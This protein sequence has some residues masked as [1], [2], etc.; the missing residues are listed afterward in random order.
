MLGG[1]T[2]QI[3]IAQHLVGPA[4]RAP[5]LG[6]DAVRIVVGQLFALLEVRVQLD[7]VDGR[8]HTCIANEQVDVAGQE[9]ADANV[10]DQAAFASFD[11]R[12]PCLDEL[13]LAWVRP[14]NQIEIDVVE[15]HTAHALL[16]GEQSLVVSMVAAGQLGRDDDVFARH[17]GF[18]DGATHHT[19]VLI[20]ERGVDEAVTLMDGGLDGVHTG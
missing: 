20:V 6:D 4:Q 7:L 13:A 18:A 11:Q 15:T 3:R 19:F 8:R 10:L 12:F 16:N 14:V 9:V 2:L 1:D 5:C 17:A